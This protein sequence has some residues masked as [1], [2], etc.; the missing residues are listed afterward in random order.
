MYADAQIIKEFFEFGEGRT[1][2][3][4]KIFAGKRPAAKFYVILNE[5]PEYEKAVK[6]CRQKGN[7]RV[8][9][10]LT[11]PEDVNTQEKREEFFLAFASKVQGT[12]KLIDSHMY[13]ISDRD[14][15]GLYEKTRQQNNGYYDY[16]VLN[17]I[18]GMF[19]GKSPREVCEIIGQ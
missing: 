9:F 1:I 2:S 18:E 7:H 11:L 16:N 8:F 3:Y 13:V 17:K 6:E 5:S 15:T 19:L 12:T 10:P 14:Y 4:S